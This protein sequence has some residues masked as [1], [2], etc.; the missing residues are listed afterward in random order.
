MAGLTAARDLRR[1]GWDVQVLEAGD[2]PGGRCRE[3]I[4][5][6]M[7]VRSGARMLYS[8]YQTTMGLINELSLTESII[9]LP[10]H[11]FIGRD[12]RQ[13]Y[14]LSFSFHRSLILGSHLRLQTKLR[15]LSLLPSLLAA[16]RHGD[17]EDLTTMSDVD[18]QSFAEW[19][20]KRSGTDFLERIADPLF[21]AARG[22]SCNEIS[23]S[24]FLSTTAYQPGHFAFALDGGMSLLANSMAKELNVSYGTE[25]IKVTEESDRVSVAFVMSG[26]QSTVSADIAVL[27]TEG[28]R[29]RTLLSRPTEAQARLLSCVR[30]NSLAIAYAILRRSNA[31]RIEFF[32]RHPDM[33]FALIEQ[34]PGD[35]LDAMRPPH[36][37][38]EFSPEL[39]RTVSSD[40]DILSLTDELAAEIASLASISKDDILQWVPQ[41]IPLMLPIPYPGYARE[42]A[43]FR[44]AQSVK[45]GR[46][47]LAGD[48]LATP[49]VGG[50][51]ASGRATA[52]TANSHWR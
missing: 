17:P 37:F 21:R 9:K 19:L 13:S 2:A 51:C 10:S 48:Y 12:G 29:A 16:R 34:V 35:P 26:R 30:Y 6:G 28:T 45:S 46:V 11:P 36:L 18:D 42:V 8:F 44:H 41:L 22:W 7:L 3:F 49:L 23:P 43:R 4:K 32:V 24:F 33:P 20:L 39:S 27:A 25:A 5:D 40:H 1:Y 31:P 14:P 15:L 47:Y 50:A 38:I 52:A